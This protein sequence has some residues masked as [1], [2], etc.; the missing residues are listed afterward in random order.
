MATTHF[1][2]DELSDNVLMETDEF[3]AATAEYTQEPGQFGELVSQHR[4]GATSQYHFDGLGSTRQ[5]TNENADVTDESTFS[6]FG[7]EVASSG[8]TVNPFG[9]QGSVG[10]HANPTTEDL[11]VRARHYRPA[12][13]RW[14]S[15]DPMPHALVVTGRIVIALLTELDA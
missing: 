2:W 3:G 7:E 14:L 1:I 4:D 13:A 8:A 6:A 15:R 5:L 9:F 11:Y 10:Y 12:I